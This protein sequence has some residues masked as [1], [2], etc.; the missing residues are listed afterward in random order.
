[1]MQLLSITEQTEYNH[2]S[3]D[4]ESYCMHTYKNFM[5]HMCF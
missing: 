2:A 3:I 4:N 1:M 5:M